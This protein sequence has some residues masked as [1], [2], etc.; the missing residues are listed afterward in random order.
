MKSTNCFSWVNCCDL[1]F[2]NFNLN[3][4]QFTSDHVK[5]WRK[6]EEKFNVQTE[7][8]SQST[9]RWFLCEKLVVNF[10]ENALMK[11]PRRKK[12]FTFNLSMHSIV[13]DFFQ[14]YSLNIFFKHFKRWKWIWWLMMMKLKQD[15]VR[16][17]VNENFI[18][19]SCRLAFSMP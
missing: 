7:I 19:S 2:L 1:N 11:I 9:L 15:E 14:K 12:L 13:L 17:F 18:E 4:T 16:L 6:T 8:E 5:I 3:S 10:D